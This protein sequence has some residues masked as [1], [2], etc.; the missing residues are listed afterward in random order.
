MNGVFEKEDVFSYLRDFNVTANEVLNEH[1]SAMKIKLTLFGSILSQNNSVITYKLNVEGDTSNIDTI[2]DEI[3][4]KLYDKIGSNKVLSVTCTPSIDNSYV[5]LVITGPDIVAQ[6]NKKM[7]D[8]IMGNSIKVKS[9]EIGKCP[10]CNSMNLDYD[11]LELDGSTVQY[12]WECKDCGAQGKEVYNANF[13]EIVA[14]TE[15]GDD[16]VGEE[17]GICPECGAEINYEESYPEGESLYYEYECPSCNGTGKEWYDLE[18]ITQSLKPDTGKELVVTEAIDYKSGDVTVTTAED[19]NATRGYYG[20]KMT[21][22]DKVR[23]YDQALRNLDR[24]KTDKI[25][26]KHIDKKQE[27]IDDDIDDE[28]TSI[29]VDNTIS[30]LDIAL[31]EVP[32][33]GVEDWGKDDELLFTADTV[34]LFEHLKE[35]EEE[36]PKYYYDNSASDDWS[37]GIDDYLSDMLEINPNSGE[38]NNTYN[39]NAPLTHHFEYTTYD[40]DNGYYVKVS[41]HRDGDVR[42]NYTTEF[43]L[44]FDS[45]DEFFSEVTDISYQY[46][47]HTVKLDN[48][49]YTVVAQ[50]FSEYVEISLNG[51][52][53]QWYDV[54]CPDIATLK[55]IVSKSPE[56]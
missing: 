33:T 35:Y 14:T 51:T 47:S 12:P 16:V 25:K 27:D 22:R 32:S 1:N 49:E 39:W 13:S 28:D 26:N 11:V 18:F 46:L 29:D 36:I 21:K 9:N 4:S 30:L 15:D 48:N 2:A 5:T 31:K 45:A 52:D 8:K 17:E 24:M 10:V 50:I 56:E 23:S 20:N 53:K 38:G 34:K 37:N 3:A 44:S 7:E 55:Q 40:T 43:L 41:I 19:D 6:G 54:Y 42:G